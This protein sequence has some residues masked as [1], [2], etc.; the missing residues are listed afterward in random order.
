MAEYRRPTPYSFFLHSKHPTPLSLST[1]RFIKTPLSSTRNTSLKSVP[2]PRLPRRFFPP[3]TPFAGACAERVFRSVNL[4]ITM[5]TRRSHGS[6]RR[7]GRARWCLSRLSRESSEPLG[8]FGIRG[9]PF[10]QSR[11]NEGPNQV[12][13]QELAPGDGQP[14]AIQ[15]DFLTVKPYNSEL[16]G[17]EA[18]TEN[19][20]KFVTTKT[21]S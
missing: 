11:R 3:K 14:S 6:D 7:S 13:G 8:S 2:S 9:S 10:G 16:A 12:P 21:R 4:G 17:T 5:A 19:R 20:L 18:I 15:S 1:H